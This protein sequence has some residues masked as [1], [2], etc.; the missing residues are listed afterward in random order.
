MPKYKNIIEAIQIFLMLLFGV[1]AL[2]CFV[3]FCFYPKSNAG[4]YGGLVVFLGIVNILILS[5]KEKEK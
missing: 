5:D 1:I 4:N 3:V 2:I